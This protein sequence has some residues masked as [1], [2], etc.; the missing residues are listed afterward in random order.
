MR[1]K[2]VVL[3]VSKEDSNVTNIRVIQAKSKYVIVDGG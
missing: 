2:E 3:M 1:G